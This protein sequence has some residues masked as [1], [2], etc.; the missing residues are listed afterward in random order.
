MIVLDGAD[1]HPSLKDLLA[2]GAPAPEVSFD[3]ATQ[4]AVL[5]YSSG[6]TAGPRG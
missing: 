3:P 5:P 1:G 4:L 2:E 6:T